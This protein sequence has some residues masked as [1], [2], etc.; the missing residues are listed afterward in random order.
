MKRTL[1]VTLAAAM[2]LAVLPV[3]GHASIIQGIHRARRHSATI[4]KHYVEVE[5]GVWVAVK[6]RRERRQVR[7]ARL[8]ETWSLDQQKVA[9]QYG[10]PVYRVREDASGQVTETWSYPDHDVEF[11]FAVP[12]G[13]LVDTKLR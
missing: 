10:W 2:V 1:F 12:S 6:G 5:D 3:P 7:F 9:S 13:T 11:V 8:P 4:G